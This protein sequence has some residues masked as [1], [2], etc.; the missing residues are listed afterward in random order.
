MSLTSKKPEPKIKERILPPKFKHLIQNEFIARLTFTER[1][2][3]LIG[4]SLEVKY[5]CL[6]EHLPGRTDPKMS[7]RVV[8]KL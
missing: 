5:E 3:L 1:V 7:V 4:Y 8:N 2:K 6:I